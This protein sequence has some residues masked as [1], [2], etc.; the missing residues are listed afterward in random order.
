[1]RKLIKV[2]TRTLSVVVLLAVGWW[3]L[4]SPLPAEIAAN[5]ATIFGAPAPLLPMLMWVAF[6]SVLFF[7]GLALEYLCR[8]LE[9][10]LR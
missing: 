2:A 7:M 1:V 10:T 8:Q 3:L 4:F 9:R 5:L 6:Y